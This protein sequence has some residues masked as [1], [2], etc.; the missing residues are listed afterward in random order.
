MGIEFSYT[1]ATSKPPGFTSTSIDNTGVELSDTVI[2]NTGGDTRLTL[3][4]SFVDEDTDYDMSIGDRID[5]YIIYS[6]DGTN[7]ES[8]EE[9]TLKGQSP[10]ASH[11]VTKTGLNSVRR[12]FDLIPI[13]PHKFKIAVKYSV[14]EE[15][16]LTLEAYTYNEQAVLSS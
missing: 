14:S 12:V 11:V 3:V 4:A 6:P 15:Q 9:D 10:V 16:L 8:S 13:A 5:F 2:D 7:Y 1:T